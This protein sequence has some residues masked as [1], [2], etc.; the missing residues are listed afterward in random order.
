VRPQAV[1]SSVTNSSQWCLPEP[2]I[3][4]V[5]RAKLD[6]WDAAS[7]QP[8]LSAD[9]RQRADRFHFRRD[10]D[11]F[12][13]GRSLLRMLLGG[14]LHVQASDLVFAYSDRGKP[15][16]ADFH[17]PSDLRFNLSH[18]D[19]MAI[20]AFTC[21]RD[22]GVDV[23][24]IKDHVEATDIAK[25]FFSKAEQQALAAVP[26]ASRNAAFFHCW[27]RKEAFV[28]AKGDGLSMPLNQF[29]VSLAP[30]RA[31]IIATR[32]DPREH[33]RW[34]MRSLDAGPDYAA[35]LVVEG[36]LRQVSER[37]VTIA[38]ELQKANLHLLERVPAQ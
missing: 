33:K 35:A 15:A 9:E 25:H 3:V 26:D 20:F 28:K 14:Y 6:G 17:S 11:R 13:V 29:D 10:C 37:A 38:S 2:G 19:I 34:S 1:E 24:R 18:S 23:E 22:I 36:A 30:E 32:P 4:H 8:C 16:L 31:E 5:W 27:V 21:G 12:V 7:L